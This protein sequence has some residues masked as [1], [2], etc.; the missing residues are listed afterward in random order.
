MS[1][2]WFRKGTCTTVNGSDVV[3]FTGADITTAPNKPVVGDAFTLDGVTLYEVIFIGSDSTGEYVRLEKAFA[4]AAVSNAKYALMRLASSTQNAK[5]VAM[6]A[7]AINQKQISL[8][9]MYEWYTSTADTVDFLG[10]D[11]TVATLK[12]YFKLT[13]EISDVGG[14]TDAITIVSNNIDAV[15]DV[16]ANM[17]AVKNV[18]DNMDEIK[19]V[20]LGTVGLSQS[21]FDLVRDQNNEEFAAS[22][23]VHFGKHG[24]GSGDNPVNEGLYTNPALANHFRLGRPANQKPAG[25]SKTTYPVINI[26]GVT[27]DIIAGHSAFSHFDVKFPAAPDGTVTYD[28]SNGEVKKHPDSATAFGYAGIDPVNREVVTNRV[29]MWGFEAFLEE[30]SQANPFVYPN[31]L[32]QSQATTMDGIATAASARPVTYYAAFDGDTTSKGKGLNFFALSAANQ[33]KVLSN[34][35]HNLYY[36]DDGRLVQWRLRQRTI[37]GV[38]GDWLRIESNKAGTLAITSLLTVKPQGDSDVVS[39]GTY[40]DTSATPTGHYVSSNA[41]ISVKGECYFLACGTVSG[42]NSG[43]YHPSF[44]RS[45]AKRA[46]D[47]KYWYNTAIS[48]TSKADCFNPAKLL[49]SSGSIASGKSGR[50]DG[51]YYDAI[52]ADGAGGVCRDMRYSANGLTPVDFYNADLRV[53][54]GEYRGFEKVLTSNIIKFNLYGSSGSITYASFAQAAGHNLLGES[55]GLVFHNGYAYKLSKHGN[56]LWVR[57]NRFIGGTPTAGDYSADIDLAK[58]FVFIPAAETDLDQV[59][60]SPPSASLET[61]SVGGSFL[62]TDVAGDPNDIIQIA[63]L[64]NGWTGSWIGVIPDGVTRIPLTR[65]RIDS[66]FLKYTNTSNLGGTWVVSDTAFDPVTNDTAPLAVGLVALAQYQ[67]FAKQTESANNAP[68]YG[69]MPASIS[70]GND[71]RSEYGSVFRESLGVLDKNNSGISHG[72]NSVTFILADNTY[73]LLSGVEHAGIKLG[74][75]ANSSGAVKSLGYNVNINQQGVKQYAATE[76]KFDGTDWGDD[77]KVTIVDGESTKTDDNGNTVKVVTHKL[78]EPIGWIKNKV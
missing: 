12:T 31:G 66:G 37:A 54:A 42:L 39:T 32:I 22:G 43:F 49:A 74:S 26:A 44:N 23:I 76:L 48:F 69:E 67:A 40:N 64:E 16:H 24:G 65:K 9:D 28:K 18:S 53:E 62:Q 1:Y 11:G 73:R 51:R 38:N 61:I 34:P 45:G 68:V 55:G 71:Y 8:D 5:L 29:D 72:E 21:H 77:G 59:L 46:S 3:R 7:A 47:D 30:V 6:A 57:L 58:P 78:K 75:P 4:Q 27:T 25:N 63:E 70:V 56:D 36:L 60:L 2:S 19:Q 10:P 15:K 52:Y 33:K 20:N 13:K 41:A 35:K 50:P 17:P 14:N